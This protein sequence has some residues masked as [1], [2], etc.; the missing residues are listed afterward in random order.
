MNIRGRPCSYERTREREHCI[1]NNRN[2]W[3]LR[4]M[5]S[6]M[7]SKLLYYVDEREDESGD[8]NSAIPEVAIDDARARARPPSP[9]H[10]P[11]TNPTG[12][13]QRTQISIGWTSCIYIYCAVMLHA[14]AVAPFLNKQ[15]TYLLRYLVKSRHLQGCRCPGVISGHLLK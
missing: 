2:Y 4:C 14:T 9:P 7:C 13:N 11:S 15:H 12:F 5:V 6:N 3:P 8:R 1:V 10:L